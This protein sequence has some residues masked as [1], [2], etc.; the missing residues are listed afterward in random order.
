MP[1]L[2]VAIALPSDIKGSLAPLA[3]GLGDVRWT[4]PAQQHVTLRFIG[5]TDDGRTDEVA[6][7]LSAVS[8][9]PF[10]LRLKGIGH[11]PP[12]GEPRV[13]WAGV[14]K[15]AGLKDLKLRVDRVLRSAGFESD[16]RKF[17][18]HVTLARLRRPPSQAGLATYLMRHSLYQSA[19]FAVSGFHLYSSRLR[20]DGPDYRLEASYHLVP[21]SEDEDQTWL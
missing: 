16:P 14:E 13:I 19:P 3:S 1:R 20:T 6:D 11:F 10:E 18:P 9:F 5:E 8:G 4:T 17:V 12:R 15:S 2:F 21:G 7:L